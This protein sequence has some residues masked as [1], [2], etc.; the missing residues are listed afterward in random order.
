MLAAVAAVPTFLVL[1]LAQAV[2][3]VEQMAVETPMVLTHQ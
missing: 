3:V 2:L 1:L